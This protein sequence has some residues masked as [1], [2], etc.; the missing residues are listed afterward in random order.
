MEN[1]FNCSRSDPEPLDRQSKDVAK[2]AL[3]PNDLRRAWIELQLPA[4]PQDLHIDAAVE[5]VFMHPRCLQQMLTAQRPLRGV[6][7]RGQQSKSP[8]VSATSL[9]FGS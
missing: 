3:R 2:T 8:L 6:E 7:K 1:G 5:N 4:Q 9:P